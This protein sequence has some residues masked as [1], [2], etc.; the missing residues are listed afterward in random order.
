MGKVIQIRVLHQIGIR[1]LF[2]HR[3]QSI[4][5]ILGIMLGVAVMVAIDLANASASRA[6]DLSTDAIAGK[7]THQIVSTPNGIPEDFYVQLLRARLPITVAP[8]ISEYA[9]T[10]ALGDRPFTLLGIDP[11]AESPFRN[12]L[13]N[14]EGTDLPQLITFLT[15]PGAILLSKDVAQRYGYS[16]CGTY[17]LDNEKPQQCSLALEISG[18]LR[19]ATVTGLLDPPDA[20]SAQA[21]DNIILADISTA[22]ELTG[23]LGRIDRIDLIIPDDMTGRMDNDLV[24]KLE[25]QIAALLPEGAVLQTVS[26]RSG[27]IKEMTSAFRVNLTALSLLALLVGLF[28]IYNTMTFS[29]VQ[30]R[31]M[32]GVL[33]CI[34]VT[35]QEIFVLILVEAIFVGFIGSALGLILGVLMGQAALRLVSQTINDLF[36][37]ISVRGVQVPIESL[38]KGSII[39]LLSTALT[40][41]PPAWEAAT[42][43][44]RSALYRSGLEDKAQKAVFVSAWGG[45]IL[46]VVGCFV[47]LG[48]PSN[49]LVISFSGTFAIIVGLAM[50]TPLTTRAIMSFIAPISARLAGLLGKLAPRDAEK[51][52]SRTSI[53][54][55]ALMVSVSVTI[56]VS[57]MI[58]SF[59]YTVVTWLTQ[60]LQGDI[61][62]S[63]PGINATQPETEIQNEVIDFIATHQDV[64]KVAKLRAV[65]VDSPAGPI[66]L[67]AIDNPI[68]D[69]RLFIH[70]DGNPD[71]VWQEML[72][73]AVSIS[74]PLANRL[75]IPANGGKISLNTTQGPRQFMVAGIFYD[76]ASTQGTVRMAMNIYQTYWNDQS[77]T[78]LALFIK[79]EADV[80]TVANELQDLLARSSQRLII[81]P[82]QV[83]RQEALTVFD[84]TFAIT[85][86]MQL[87]A[88]VVAFIGILSAL[89]AVQLDKQRQFGVLRAIGMTTR[90]IW[91]LVLMQTGL[92]GATAGILAMPTGYILS[93]ILIY[94]INRR[95]FGWTLQMQVVPEPFLQALIIAVAAAVLAGLYPAYRTSKLLTT[96]ALRGE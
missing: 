31:P 59:R 40:A 24:K 50:L 67:T 53:A 80:I 76:Y 26:S 9:V 38:L 20:L 36:F 82:N 49:N 87:L 18:Y 10:D 71:E 73:G 39:G 60:T 81:R 94:I 85:G 13:G 77:V 5:M 86:A 78:S 48:I 64:E 96:E 33:R 75:S 3:L 15:Q 91:G 74:E 11:F 89:L 19:D 44:P 6:F 93:L 84:R 23:R 61:Y 46:G 22:Q 8:V 54:V 56:G 45:A 43:P 52:L 16:G 47:L 17:S 68:R 32:F 58:S 37:V 79:P 35:R 63:A 29:V 69:A 70:A 27:A 30:R 88:T 1:Y 42:V 7:A 55:A 95:S 4:L 66:N 90:Q 14:T 25:Q 57:L 34:G 62:I 72:V 41:L 83:L 2:R 92:L 12:Y 65:S 21:L 28:L 51:S